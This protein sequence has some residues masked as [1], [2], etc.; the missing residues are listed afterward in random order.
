MKKC[1]FCSLLNQHTHSVS[2]ANISFLPF[3]KPCQPIHTMY[4]LTI[5]RH[6]SHQEIRVAHIC[7]PTPVCNEV[8]KQDVMKAVFINT[9]TG[10]VVIDEKVHMFEVTFQKC[11]QLFNRILVYCNIGFPDRKVPN[12]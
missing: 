3:A 9:W 6:I 8:Y 7:K 11:C 2:D 12:T 5:S 10:L 4:H 1:Q